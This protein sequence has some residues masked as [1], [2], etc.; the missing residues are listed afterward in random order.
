AAYLAAS[1]EL[2]RQ[3]DVARELIS[4][5]SF[6]TYE[7]TDRWHE[8][9]SSDADLLYLLSRYFPE[10]LAR[11]P[12]G[13]LDSLA[14]HVQAGEYNSLSAANAILALDAYAQVVTHGRPGQLSISAELA[15]GSSQPLA[16]PPESLFP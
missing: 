6:G 15:D 11:L 7:E 4:G 16:L 1:Y 10:R 9:M 3:P 13:V 5:V 2:M 8:P 12:D 14:R